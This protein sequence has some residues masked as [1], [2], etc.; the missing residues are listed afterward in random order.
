MPLPTKPTLQPC[1]P[2]HSGQATWAQVPRQSTSKVTGI[3]E[4]PVS[5][6][7]PTNGQVLSYDGSAWTPAA[8]VTTTVEDLLTST[9]ATSALSANQ[10]KVLNDALANKADITALQAKAFG[11]G[12]LGAG[13]APSTSKVTGIQE[14]PVSATAPTPGQSI[15]L[16]RI[17]LDSC[18]C[19]NHYS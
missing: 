9:S 17:G 16:R 14:I 4:I 19:C 1:K 12:D 7:A 13:T 3:Q 5:A 8:P 18:C 11:T 2:K 10:G 15:I 6:T